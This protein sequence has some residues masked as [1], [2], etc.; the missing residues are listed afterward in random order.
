M[1]SSPAGGLSGDLM[2][3]TQGLRELDQMLAA[4]RKRIRVVL[5]PVPRDRDQG[6][7]GGGGAAGLDE[8]LKRPRAVDKD[9][10]V[11]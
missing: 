11:I 5:G 4:A 9:L 6:D 3:L 7:S 1:L 2:T 10:E 8:E